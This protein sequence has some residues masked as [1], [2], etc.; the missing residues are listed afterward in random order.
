ML[1]EG[2]EVVIMMRMK[3]VD[4]KRARVIT[5][6]RYIEG[7]NRASVYDRHNQYHNVNNTSVAIED[8]R[9]MAAGGSVYTLCSHMKKKRILLNSNFV[10]KKM[11]TGGTIEI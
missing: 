10:L 3:G 7:H 9:K 6:M 1:R 2:K 8:Y 4:T 5:G 11:T